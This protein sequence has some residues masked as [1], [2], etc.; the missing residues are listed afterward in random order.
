MDTVRLTAE[1]EAI[2]NRMDSMSPQFIY[3]DEA[4]IDFARMVAIM[5]DRIRFDLASPAVRIE[6]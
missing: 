6:G 5:R 1:D 3:E 4:E 2:Y